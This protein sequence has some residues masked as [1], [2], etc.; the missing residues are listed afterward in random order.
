V[1]G[2]VLTGKYHTAPDPK[3]PPDALRA[4]INAGS[5][6]VSERGMRIAHE[7][8]AVAEEVGRSP[9]QVALN[10]VRQQGHGLLPIVGARTEQQ[11]RD[12]LAC[13]EF[14]LEEPHLRRLDEVS[15]IELGF[16]HDFLNF[17]RLLEQR[18]GGTYERMDFRRA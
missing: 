18:Y 15:R 17:P 9:A 7:V 8:Q 5:Q 10:W 13:L 4:K 16:P 3:A 6:R 1:G 11:L 2:G 14:S 12:N